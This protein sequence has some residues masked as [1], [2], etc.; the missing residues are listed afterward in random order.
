MFFQFTNFG[1]VKDIG[2]NVS[3]FGLNVVNEEIFRI[4]VDLKKVDTLITVKPHLLRKKHALK[5]HAIS[6]ES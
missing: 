4:D 3:L 1:N 6:Y 2:R 5:G